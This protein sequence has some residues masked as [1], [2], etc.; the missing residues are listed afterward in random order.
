[1]H[2]GARLTARRRRVGLAAVGLALAFAFVGPSSAGAGSL[3]FTVAGD[4]S[5]ALEL[6]LPCWPAP[7]ACALGQT[8][9][10][11]WPSTSVEL[12]EAQVG[13]L[14]D[15]TLLLTE[16]YGV[17]ALGLDGRL[18]QWPVQFAPGAP[19]EQLLA[20]AI[21]TDSDGSAAAIVSSNDPAVDGTVVRV[22]TD[23]VVT[24]LG[25]IPTGVD[26]HIAALPDGGA[27]VADGESRVWHAW[28]D[29]RVTVVAGSRR[30]GF[31]GDGA[32]ATAA[33]LRKPWAIAAM[34][35]GGFVVSDAGNDRVRRV[36]PDG[37]IAT[38]LG[39]GRSWREGARATEVNGNA[40]ALLPTGDGGLI[41]AQ[42]DQLRWLAPNGRVGMF[43]LGGSTVR[44]ADGIPAEILGLE[45]LP[46]GDLVLLT[47][48][49]GFPTR[50]QVRVVSPSARVQ[51]LAVSFTARDR[52]RARA[53]LEILATRGASAQVDVTRRQRVVARADVALRPGRNRVAI[54]LGRSGDVHVLRVRAES[55]D[56]AIAAHRLTVIPGPMLSRSAVSATLRALEDASTDVEFSVLYRGCRRQT[57]RRFSCHVYEYSV[58]NTDRVGTASIRLRGDG[59]LEYVERD[60]RGRLENRQ[61]LEPTP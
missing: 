41:F 11:A 32:A 53:F 35:D 59:L 22:S 46:Q 33:R 10:A 21:D 48:G 29:G 1:M 9:L 5:D 31:S 50:M 4:A 51:R 20:E 42:G 54:R 19:Q 60:L 56:G 49:N 40:S 8:P 3:A 6:P 34:P 15:G 25:H 12:K 39:G 26:W 55:V 18:R 45:A 2:R 57:G 30:P 27:L 14:P 58:G 24:R 43:R 38:V 44:N 47:A 16:P 61:L 7:F 23:R 17:I 13:A 36:Q 28:P 37:T 52:A